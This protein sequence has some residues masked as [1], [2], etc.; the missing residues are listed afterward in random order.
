[1]P[2]MLAQIWDLASVV[3]W[4]RNACGHDVGQQPYLL[5]GGG[6][7]GYHHADSPSRESP[8]EF[9][10]A[11]SV[12]RVAIFCQSLLMFWGLYYTPPG[13][14]YLYL[15]ITGTIFPQVPCL[16]DR[17]TVLRRANTTGGCGYVAGAAG[18][19]IPYF[20]RTERE[21]RVCR[22]RPGGVR[23]VLGCCW[24]EGQIGAEE[25]R[26]LEQLA[27]GTMVSAIPTIF[28]VVSGFVAFITIVVTIKF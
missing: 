7:L 17:R 2:A 8:I 21:Y 16:C 9:K 14:V 13:A 24:G 3:L 6:I 18:A 25:A 12:N 15:N 22:F 28:L 11:D 19:I 23:L 1:M 26:H 4:L 27:L 5:A 10:G 20:S